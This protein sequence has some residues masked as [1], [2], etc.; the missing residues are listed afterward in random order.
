M[1]HYSRCWTGPCPNSC[2]YCYRLFISTFSYAVYPRLKRRRSNCDFFLLVWSMKST[3]KSSY[4]PIFDVPKSS[5]GS[6]KLVKMIR[7]IVAAC[8]VFKALFT[9]VSTRFGDMLS[10]SGELDR[11]ISM[12]SSSCYSEVEF[13]MHITIEAGPAYTLVNTAGRHDL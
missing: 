9:Y 4:P 10:T 11:Q 5:F 13:D 7:K 3:Y 6:H 12:L 2:S 1:D 8:Y